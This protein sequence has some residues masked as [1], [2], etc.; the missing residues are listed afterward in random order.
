MKLKTFNILNVPNQRRQS[1]AMIG[2]NKKSGTFRFNEAAVLKMGLKNHNL[3]DFH[4]DEDDT[5]AW[6]LEVVKKDGFVLRFKN[7]VSPKGLV[8]QSSIMARTIFESVKCT[9]ASGHIK[10]GAEA[11]KFEKRI[12]WPLITASLVN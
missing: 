5:E 2:C 1:A 6:Y 12:L 3:I 9:K 8:T 10:I 11:I 4:Q 7:S